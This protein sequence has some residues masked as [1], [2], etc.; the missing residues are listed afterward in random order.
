MAQRRDRPV[1]ER[2]GGLNIRL[3][4]GRTMSVP[5]SGLQAPAPAGV[6]CFCGEVVEHSDSE[7]IRLDARWEADG[8]EREQSWVAH[9]K[10]LFDRLHDR[11]RDEGPFFGEG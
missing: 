7:R 4:D 5:V 10:C 2:T 11:A 9:R 3:P 8:T 1:I 6:C